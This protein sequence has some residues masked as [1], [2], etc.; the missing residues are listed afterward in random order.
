MN[1][2]TWGDKGTGTLLWDLHPCD[3]AGGTHWSTLPANWIKTN[4]R[5]E[6]EIE[7][8]R[9]QAAHSRAGSYTSIKNKGYVLHASRVYGIEI[10]VVCICGAAAAQGWVVV[11]L[12]L[13]RIQVLYL[14]VCVGRPLCLRFPLGTRKRCGVKCC[15]LVIKSRTI[16]APS[17]I[18][19]WVLCLRIAG[20]VLL[21]LC[22]AFL[23]LQC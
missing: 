16:L 4:D 14:G 3:R 5:M 19:W 8:P 20:P 23:K 6:M 2:R 10:S 12:G 22:L 11:P 13:W 21:L 9:K 7:Y 17:S 18:V 1:R 15:C